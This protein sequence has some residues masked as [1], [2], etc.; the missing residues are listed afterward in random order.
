MDRATDILDDHLDAKSGRRTV[1]AG[2]RRAHGGGDRG[3][4]RRQSG[5]P[6]GR[7]DLRRLDRRRLRPRGGAQGGEGRARR[8]PIAARIGAAARPAGRS[9]RASRRRAGGRALRQ[10]HVPEPGH[11]GHLRRAGTAAAASGHLRIEPGRRRGRRSGQAGRICRDGMRP[12]SR[13]AGLRSRPI[14]ASKAT[15]CRSKRPAHAMS[16]SRRK[17]AATKPPCWR[18][19]PST[20]TTSPSSAAAR[21]PK[22]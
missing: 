19:S 1:R 2:D 13:A 8:R 17:A 9:W 11:D 12:G 10:E 6:A 5:D 15:R 20:S 14:A 21:R 18:R 16:W 4:G 7:H 22:R 3:Q